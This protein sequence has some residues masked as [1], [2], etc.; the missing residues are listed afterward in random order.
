LFIALYLGLSRL[1][2]PATVG[3]NLPLF[4][5]QVGLESAASN[6]L[7]PDLLVQRRF[8]FPSRDGRLLEVERL[9]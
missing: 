2:S 5:G 7:D 4:V 1:T 9:G 6:N 3:K 8:L